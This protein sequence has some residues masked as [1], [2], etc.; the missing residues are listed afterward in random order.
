MLVDKKGQPIY[1]TFDL[2]GG[3][4]NPDT[5]KSPIDPITPPNEYQTFTPTSTEG[6]QTYTPPPAAPK[7]EYQTFSP[8]PTAE[9]P[10]AETPQAGPQ[11]YS[12]TLDESGYNPGNPAYNK[13][14]EWESLKPLRDSLATMDSKI[15]NL[16]LQQ[17][18]DIAQK[19]SSDP[20][21]EYQDYE[22]AEKQASDAKIAQH[23]ALVANRP[24][25][26][27][28]EGTQTWKE[29]P[30]TG[31]WT[32]TVELTPEQKAINEQDTAFKGELADIR[33]TAL[34][35][36]RDTLETP[37]QIPGEAPDYTGTT[38]PMP[39][40]E[41]TSSADIPTLDTTQPPPTYAE[42]G[43]PIPT[44]QP[45]PEPAP[46]YDPVTGQ[47]PE[48]KQPEP[49]P[50]YTGPG[51]VQDFQAPDVG[52]M[53]EV[54]APEPVPT[55]TGPEG[56]APTFT[57]TNADV[58][59][60]DLGLG[61]FEDYKGPEGDIPTY[62][63]VGMETPE[64]KGLEGEVPQY[65][66][67]KEKVLE[68]LLARSEEDIARGKEQ[69][70]A[71]LIAQG[72]PPGTDAYKTEMQAYD[73]ALTDARQQAQ[74]TA[75]Q[76]ATTEYQNLL[77]GRKQGQSESQDLFNNAVTK[78]GL[79][80]GE[81]RQQFISDMQSRGMSFDEAVQEYE[82]QLD[83]RRTLAGEAGT[84]F[85][86][87]VT[88]YGLLDDKQKTIFDAAI[89]T[90]GMNLE[91]S[92]TDFVNKMAEAG[93]S[94]DDAQR[95]FD[96]EMEVRTQ[97]YQESQ[98]IF[99]NAITKQGVDLETARADFVAQMESAGMAR[100]DANRMFDS[101]L[102]TR[103]QKV[104][105]AQNVF[106]N[107]VITRN[108]KSA[109]AENLFNAS[110]AEYGLER[111]RAQDLYGAEKEEYN[112]KRQQALEKFAA[113]METYGV[114]RSEAIQAFDAAMQVRQMTNS[115]LLTEYNAD[116]QKH[117][118]EI[119]DALLE[120][121]IPLNEMQ[122]LTG[123]Q[124]ISIPQFMGG[125]QAIPVPGADYLGVSQFSQTQNLAIKQMLNSLQIAQQNNDQAM[126][127]NLLGGLFDL[128]VSFVG[129]KGKK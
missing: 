55:Y 10:T 126:A 27:T 14:K 88:T 57:P 50:D 97:K 7:P 123:G 46:T 92:K 114:K 1:N 117:T 21:Q 47:M 95:L 53:P 66:G 9:T 128:G 15:R 11:P 110:I 118:Q 39:Q 48:L 76:I 99:D 122:I 67:I 8:A 38:A 41:Q 104:L 125:G 26:V 124:Q 85:S 60:L 32:A 49:V 72:I 13:I 5:L 30:V 28:P 81:A 90:R 20:T 35:G 93:M 31:E 3:L 77:Q 70:H 34:A 83:K 113:E 82:S 36:A 111:Q 112:S 119:S 4:A 2:S 16:Y 40:L 116:M 45:P 109:D 79:E 129:Y 73:R 106:D 115:E 103:R 121:S 17:N 100:E 56:E 33:D 18:P 24:T 107:D 22:L 6:L 42:P 74:I 120:R 102:E 87:G 61:A 12:P 54:K 96:N 44:F 86:A 58:P 71:Q 64:V 98:Q 65:E 19:L 25:I 29:D 59:R 52:A 101:Q 80:S 75:S 37:F 94:R 108:I 51:Q 78:Y 68:S 69:K 84:E 127:N 105:E 63:G 89:T 62:Q 23:E 43:K 91:E